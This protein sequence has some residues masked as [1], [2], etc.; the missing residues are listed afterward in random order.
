MINLFSFWNRGWN[1]EVANTNN[2]VTVRQLGALEGAVYKKAGRLTAL[3]EQMLV[4]CMYPP[5]GGCSGG[6]MHEVWD[7]INTKNGIPTDKTYPY[8][9]EVEYIM[10]LWAVAL[11]NGSLCDF[12]FFGML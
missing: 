3:S 10:M 8:T 6:W 2:D 12:I 9:A 1:F 5:R 11:E 4:D 7:F